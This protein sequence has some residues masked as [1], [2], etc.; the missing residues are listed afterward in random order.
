MW[1]K[2]IRF[3]KEARIELTKVTWSTKDEL[4]GSTIVVIILSLIMSAFVG[5]VD[6]GLSNM[7][8]L[9]LR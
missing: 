1:Q 8:G 6:L 3:L 9:I 2:L 5:L 7:S 4:I